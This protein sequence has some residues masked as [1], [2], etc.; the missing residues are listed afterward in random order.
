MGGVR[1]VPERCESP[2]GVEQEGIAECE[3]DPQRDDF[4]GLRDVAALLT[5]EVLVRRV[6]EVEKLKLIRFCKRRDGGVGD[7][8]GAKETLTRLGREVES[9]EK[10]REEEVLKVRSKWS[11][12]AV[13]HAVEETVAERDWELGSGD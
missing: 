10:L 13:A 3:S 6:R 1:R 11:S 9:Q 5:M 7:T 2:K 12:I 8:V 4:E